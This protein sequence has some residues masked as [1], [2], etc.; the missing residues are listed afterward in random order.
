MILFNRG[1]H[2]K[3]EKQAILIPAHQVNDVLRTLI[4]QF[5]SILFDIFIHFD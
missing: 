4:Q 2:G 5:D 1:K 3:G